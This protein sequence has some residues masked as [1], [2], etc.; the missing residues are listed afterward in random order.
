MRLNDRV[1]IV[2]GSGQGIGAAF[3]RGLAAEGAAVVIADLAADRAEATAR[4]IQSAGGRALAVSVDV[5]DEESVAAMPTAVL[6]HFGRIDILVNNAALFTASFPRRH[7]S[8]LTVAEWDRMMA[9]NVRGPFLC[10]RA[11]FPA[12]QAQGG[13]KIVN[14]SSSTIWSGSKDFLHYVTSKSAVLGFTRQLA[15]EVGDYNICVNAITPGLTT[16]EG[17][18]RVYPPEYLEAFAARRCF[19]RQEVPAD[20]VG[21]VVFLSSSESDF[22]TGQTLNVDGGDMFH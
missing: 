7:F 9:V 1:A 10:C 15:R 12:M 22:M 16:S 21:A 6:E 8:E 18:E 11:V 19:K 2:T 5:S 13:G 20:L 4:E 14:I 17:V 3:A